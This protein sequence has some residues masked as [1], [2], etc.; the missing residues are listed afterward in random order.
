[1]QGVTLLNVIIMLEKLKMM[2]ALFG[3]DSFY[4]G[5]WSEIIM[6]VFLKY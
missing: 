4:M 5:R 1:M 2:K 6:G 3:L